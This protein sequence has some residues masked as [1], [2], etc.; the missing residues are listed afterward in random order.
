[1]SIK[2]RLNPLFKVVLFFW[3]Q[4][5]DQHFFFFLSGFSYLSR[6]LIASITSSPSGHEKKRKKALVPCPQGRD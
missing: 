2:P 5:N 3:T 1:M 4:S 6:R